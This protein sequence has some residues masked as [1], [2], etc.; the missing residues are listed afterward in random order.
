[1]A[2]EARTPKAMANTFQEDVPVVPRWILA[3]ADW[4]NIIAG[5]TLVIPFALMAGS[6]TFGWFAM[7]GEVATVF[8]VLMAVE[9]VFWALG[10]ALM[11]WTHVI[12]DSAYPAVAQTVITF[13]GIFLFLNGLYNGEAGR[14]ISFGYVL[15]P[16]GRVTFR[17]AAAYYGT[18]CFMTGTAMGLRGAWPL[19][20]KKFVSPFWASACMWLGSWTVGMAIWVPMLLDGLAR[21][22]SLQDPDVQMYSEKTFAWSANHVFQ[23][24]GACSLT[25]GAI[26]FA[27]LNDTIWY[28]PLRSKSMGSDDDIESS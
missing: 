27:V 25:A 17:D 21:Y 1:M 5:I 20:K 18:G 4:S 11:A 13:G 16:T 7:E 24:L 15:D 12:T 8:Q 22:G 9:G 19:S 23:T 14:V 3:A 28:R 26:L 6:Y 10:G 2:Q